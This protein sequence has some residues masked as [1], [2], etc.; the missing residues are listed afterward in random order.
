MYAKVF[1]KLKTSIQIMIIILLLLPSISS[2]LQLLNEW[3]NERMFSQ[4][5]KVIS[6][7]L[8]SFSLEIYRKLPKNFKIERILYWNPE[9]NN[10]GL[11]T[12][13]CKYS[14]STCSWPKRQCDHL[15]D[16][17]MKLDAVWVTVWD[18]WNY[19]SRLNSVS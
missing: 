2:S 12:Q 14:L 6:L 8:S 5:P 1:Y 11:S 3:M 7:W 16:L 18:F 4:R 13:G 15:S 19:Q 10:P 17:I 9:V